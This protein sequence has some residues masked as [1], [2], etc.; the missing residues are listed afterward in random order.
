M[1]SLGTKELNQAD[2]LFNFKRDLFKRA[3]SPMVFIFLGFMNLQVMGQAVQASGGKKPDSSLFVK[4]S[5]VPQY[6]VTKASRKNHV[7][8]KKTFSIRMIPK[9]NIGEEKSLSFKISDKT[10]PQLDT[11]KTRL[12][13]RS[14]SSVAIADAKTKNSPIRKVDLVKSDKAKDLMKNLR[15][16]D[17]LKLPTLVPVILP[18][19]VSAEPQVEKV[20]KWNAADVK[21]LQALIIL[22]FHKNYDMALG[23]FA[24]LEQDKVHRYDARYHYALAA[25]HLKMQNESEQVLLKLAEESAKYKERALVKLV[26]NIKTTSRDLALVLEKKIKGKTLDPD[27]MDA[28]LIALAKA[29]IDKLDLS[30]AMEA[31]SSIGSK[32]VYKPE[33]E[34]LRAL[35]YYRSNQVNEALALHQD[36][37]NNR[38]ALREYPW[39]LSSL[40]AMT[41]GRLYFQKGQYQDAFKTYLKVAKNHPLWLQ[42]LVESAWTQIL[43]QDYE[44]AA[45]NMFSLHTDYFKGAYQPESYLVRTVGYLNLCQ[46]G[47]SLAVLKDF[48]RKYSYTKARVENFIK[49]KKSEDYYETVK[50]LLKS[51]ELKEVEGLPRSLIIEMARQPRFIEAQKGINDLEDESAEFLAVSKRLIEQE[52]KTLKVI[53]GIKEKIANLKR[54]S[55]QL[56]NADAKAKMETELSWQNKLRNSYELQYDIL[57][58]SRVSLKRVREESLARLNKVKLELRGLASSVLEGRLKSVQAELSEHLKQSELLEYEIFNGAGE[59][60]RFQMAGGEVDDKVKEALVPEKSQSMKWGFKGEIWEDEVGH[61]RSSLK[62]VCPKEELAVEGL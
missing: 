2:Y 59:H 51:P 55:E 42:S 25:Y 36:L 1:N 60:L 39:D 21:M 28:F 56:K 15:A 52:K 29:K 47:D 26:G 24:E 16:A 18:N 7:Y 30:A 13:K 23:L 6:D 3:L 37:E 50:T 14:I 49:S 41:L 53:E 61:Y 11:I 38:E 9:L 35:V 27:K 10:L 40:N 4:K 19:L 58:T 12:T 8:G 57:K 54:K 31:V 5:G 17:S 43:T 33:A 20:K 32:S 45:G 48:K 44:G 46:Y 34:F 22:E 62:S